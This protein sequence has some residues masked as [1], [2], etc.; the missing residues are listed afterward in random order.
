[1]SQFEYITVLTSFVVAVG[2]SQLL[3][4]WGRLYLGRKTNAPYALQV[5]AS[6]LLLL[7][8]LQSIWGYWGFREVSWDFGRFLIVLAPLL[9]LVGA[10]YIVLPPAIGTS[11]ASPSPRDHYYEVHRAI[12]ILLAAWIALGTIA[13]FTLVEPRL[14]LGQGLRF[15]GVVL[16]VVLGFTT[17]PVLHWWGLAVIAVFQ[18]LF[19]RIVTPILD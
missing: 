11:S 16:L 4:G 1:L 8:L 19:V 10:A 14:H 18:L 15:A 6:G 9:P 12:F 13:E 17:R 3:S 5:T 2:V 7:A